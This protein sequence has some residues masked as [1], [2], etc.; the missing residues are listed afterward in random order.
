V[1]SS[2]SSLQTEVERVERWLRGNK[3]TIYLAVDYQNR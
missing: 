2:F 3:S 1:V